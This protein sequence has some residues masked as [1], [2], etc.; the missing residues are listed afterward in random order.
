MAQATCGRPGGRAPPV[1]ALVPS[2]VPVHAMATSTDALP[3]TASE[4]VNDVLVPEGAL[5][6]GR[7]E[8]AA[9]EA[10]I[11]RKN[12][13]ETVTLAPHM[14]A[15]HI[16]SV[17]SHIQGGELVNIVDKERKMHEP[18]I[19]TTSADAL[20]RAE[21]PRVDISASSGIVAT[22]EDAEHENDVPNGEIPI[23]RPG[24]PM[25]AM[26]GDFLEL[27]LERIKDLEVRHVCLR[28]C[29]RFLCQNGIV[30]GWIRH[31]RGR[32]IETC[33]EWHALTPR[34][35]WH[36]PSLPY[37]RT[38]VHAITEVGR[39]PNSTPY[40]HRRGAVGTPRF[41]PIDVSRPG[42][43]VEPMIHDAEPQDVCN[44]FSEYTLIGEARGGNLAE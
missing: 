21:T 31:E 14:L 17:C 32:R 13:E 44:Y 29:I 8:A 42:S 7:Q 18:A 33:E 15:P 22:Q 25:L 41:W 4:E 30:Y 40:K 36:T 16:L 34:H 27:I 5:Q 6:N 28:P 20:V 1:G 3:H 2:Q 26:S 10:A 11:G 35:H 43:E 38:Y 19:T 9:D 37:K 39:L 23:L 24:A 12:T